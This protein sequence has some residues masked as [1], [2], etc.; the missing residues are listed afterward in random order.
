[1][2][3]NKSKETCHGSPLGTYESLLTK[4]NI[5][6]PHKNFS[7][8]KHIKKYWQKVSNRNVKKR[9]NWEKKLNNSKLKKTF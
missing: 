8:Q 7:Y 2:V 3:S 4:Q 9:M 6:W 1:M 5:N